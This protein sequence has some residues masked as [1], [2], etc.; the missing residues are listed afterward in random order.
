MDD[1]LDDI[2]SYNKN[3]DKNVLI[4]FDD[5]I[6]DIKYNK[7]FIFRKIFVWRRY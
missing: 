7:N 4:A 1:V 5:M 2:N 6:A 3:R